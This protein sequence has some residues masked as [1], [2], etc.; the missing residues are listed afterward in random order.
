MF[1][2]QKRWYEKNRKE[3]EEWAEFF[4]DS[5]AAEIDWFPAKSSGC[6]ALSHILRRN[7]AYSDRLE[8][9]PTGMYLSFCLGSVIFGGF[10][11]W[12]IPMDFSKVV[13][14]ETIETIPFFIGA[15][16]IIFGIIRFL[17][18][19]RNRIFD[20]DVGY[21]WI[22]KQN[23]CGLDFP[24]DENT[25]KPPVSISNIHAIQLVSEKC[26]SDNDRYNSY[27]LNLVLKNG[28]RINVVDH[29]DLRAIR[30]DAKRLADFISVPVWDVIVGGKKYIPYGLKNKDIK[31]CDNDHQKKE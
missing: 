27:E 7:L 11:L 30:D 22:G 20:C 12:L 24:Y 26:G 3:A 6:K 15:G 13:R 8:F 31:S 10:I 2:F 18:R 4:E 9:R 14:F 1:G 28:K 29:A 25:T 5:L 21:Y 19:C 17:L 16:F 23:I